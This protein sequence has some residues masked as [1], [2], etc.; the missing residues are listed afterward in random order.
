MRQRCQRTPE[1]VSRGI[2]VCDRWQND[3]RAFLVDMGE[4]PSRAYTID[5]IDN[6]G[7]YMPG[8]CRWATAKVQANNRRKRTH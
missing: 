6:D 8:N 1:Y 7:H 2:T 3:F 5:R 4:R